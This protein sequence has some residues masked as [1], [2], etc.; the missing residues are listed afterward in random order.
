MSA[1]A[2]SLVTIIALIRKEIAESRVEGPG[3]QR[4]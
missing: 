4:W 3:R 1:D 2:I